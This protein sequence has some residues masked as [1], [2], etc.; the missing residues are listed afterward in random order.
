[1][2]FLFYRKKQ[3]LCGMLHFPGVRY[4]K[5][6]S[7]FCL[8]AN[9][10]KHKVKIMQ[11][12]EYNTW[13]SC[14]INLSPKQ[15]T[16]PLS[17][18]GDFFSDDSLP[19]H[20]QR[21]R[22]WRDY[23]L[24]DDFYRDI[25]GS[26]AGLA[27]FYKLNVCLVEAAF[28]IETNNTVPPFYFL[29]DV[30]DRKI[31]T[32]FFLKEDELRNPALVLKTL[33]ERYNLSWYRDQLWEWLE[34]GLSVKGAKEFIETIDLV[35]LYESLQR[36]YETAWLFC[37][38]AGYDVIQFHDD[39]DTTIR[40]EC[41]D[42][43]SIYRLSNITSPAHSEKI[44]AVVSKI[45]HKLPTVQ[46]IVDLGTSPVHPAKLFLLVLTADEENGTAQSLCCML[47]ESCNDIADLTVLVHYS[48]SFLSGLNKGHTFFRSA[49]KCPVVYLSG[50][51]LLPALYE[52]R[53]VTDECVNSWERWRKQGENFYAGAEF[54]IG[55][56]A[57]DASLFCMH[58]CA[59]SLLTALIR[60]GLGYRINNH[61]LSRLLKLTQLFTND[62]AN[63]FS[64][65][66]MEL[67]EI[68][69]GAYIDVRYKDNFAADEKAVKS[70]LPIVRKLKERA[71]KV[72]QT[73]IL[74]YNL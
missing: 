20:L 24:K 17:V 12:S 5:S 13:A 19:G 57:Y 16:D 53:P 60:V 64:N 52:I 39:T 26:P 68:L 62:L 42:P 8:L 69:K 46:A 15:I 22:D 67:F 48:S 73:S 1:M 2:P 4:T 55:K 40:V 66:P 11:A 65:E 71:V 63:V 59:E 30:G 23:V 9:T 18:F 70:L 58:Q 47:E 32:T 56:K 21:L 37:Q 33:F 28:L 31:T 45:K 14:P 34:H 74:A 72:Q 10:G 54:F 51:L 43:V 27:Y 61:N 29:R 7:L 25:K 49:L 38:C 6:V 41:D 36:L 50:E 44:K 3:P 35:Y